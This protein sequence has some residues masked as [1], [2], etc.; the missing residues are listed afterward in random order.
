[1]ETAYALARLSFVIDWFINVGNTLKAWSPSLGTNIL[2]AFLT[3]EEKYTQRVT[4]T[5]IRIPRDLPTTTET[6]NCEGSYSYELETTLKT[7]VPI[8]RND[9][10][11]VPR[12]DFNLNLDKIFALVL[13]FAKAKQV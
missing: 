10:A 7:R 4:E 1:V 2:A 9:L 6:V 5:L 11:I 3:F 12:M 8:S 13:L